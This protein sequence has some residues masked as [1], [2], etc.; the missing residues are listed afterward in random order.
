MELPDAVGRLEERVLTASGMLA[1]YSDWPY[2]EQVFKLERTVWQAG[3][4]TMREVRYGV[5]SLPRTV[6]SA[7]ADTAASIPS[8]SR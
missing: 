1:G 6:A 5:T 7:M 3:E 8:P 2:L 4:E